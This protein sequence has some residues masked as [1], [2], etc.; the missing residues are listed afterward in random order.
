MGLL[1][2]DNIMFR[3]KDLKKSAK[4]YEKELGMKKVWEDTHNGMIGFAFPHGDSE[5]VIHSNPEIPNPDFSFLVDNVENFCKDFVKKGHK[6][7]IK[8]F[9]IRCG[10]L[11]VISDEDGN[12]IPIC[13]LTKF[14]GKP[15]YD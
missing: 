15:K 11:A 14:G 7:I 10:K 3:V 12:S 9:D 8:P 13:D 2:I 4:F 6:I 5:I 1:K